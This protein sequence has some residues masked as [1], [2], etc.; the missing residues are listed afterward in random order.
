MSESV[1][2]I[3]TV[4][5]VKK[6]KR[7]AYVDNKELLAEIRLMKTSGKMSE[8]LGGMILAI[9]RRYSSKGSWSGY[10]WKNDMIGDA[11]LTVCKYLHNFNEEKSKNPFSYITEIVYHSF[12]AHINKEKKVA[13]MKKMIY[14]EHLQDNCKLDK[15]REKTDE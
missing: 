14:E 7:V 6:A 13:N 15:F 4:E 12:V 9:A 1:K 3:G 11:C 8:R 10:T 2:Q 5:K